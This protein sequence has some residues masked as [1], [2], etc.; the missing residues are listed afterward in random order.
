M[1]FAWATP[2]YLLDRMSIEQIV[3]YY[4]KGWEARELEAKIHW[5]TYGQ[6]LQGDDDQKP[7]ENTDFRKSHPDGKI[8]NGAWKLSR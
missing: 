3:Y 7:S 2:D 8:E 6:L 5:G 1:M 4:N